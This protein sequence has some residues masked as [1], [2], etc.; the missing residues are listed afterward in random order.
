MTRIVTGQP[1]PY[2]KLFLRMG[3]WIP[4]LVF[5]FATGVTA[6]SHVELR[7]AERFEAEGRNATAIVQDRYSRETTDSDGDRHTSYY[8]VLTFTT[9]AGTPVEVTDSVSHGTYDRSPPGSE[10]DIRYLESDPTRIESRVGETRSAAQILQG[11]ALVFG[12][13]AL[14]VLWITGRRAVAAVRARR[15]GLREMAVVTGHK[16]TFWRVN[17]QPRYRLTWREASGR[18]GVSLA[19][20]Y[21]DLNDIEPGSEIAVYQGLTRAWWAGDVGERTEPG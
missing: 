3:G 5:F 15:Y 7:L 17:N 1:V 18:T 16:R 19:H 2:W 10:I 4:A 9:R 20:R 11:I 8:L 14:V 13:A 21:E 6:I 12:V